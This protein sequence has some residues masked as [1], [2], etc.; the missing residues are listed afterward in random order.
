MSNLTPKPDTEWNI[1]SHYEQ[2]AYLANQKLSVMPV[3]GVV[4]GLC[5]CSQFH[6]DLKDVG[7][8]PASAG[9]QKDATTDQGQ[10]EKWWGMNP[11]WNLAIHCV[12]CGLVVFDFDPRNG[13]EDSYWRL[14]D[15]TE[16]MIEDTWIVD[17]GVYN[18]KGK[19]LRG[20]HIYFRLEQDVALVGD[21]KKLGYPG[22]DVKRNGYVMA[23]GSKHVSG[24]EYSWRK[25]HAPWE[26]PLAVIPQGLLETVIKRGGGSGSSR[27]NRITD[28]EG[29]DER[30]ESVKSADVKATPYAQAAL[31]RCVA[32]LKG[33]RRGDSRNNAMNAM[34][35]SLGHL[36]GGGQI[37][38]SK[39]RDELMAAAAESYGGDWTMKKSNTESVLREYGGG[40]EEG[41]LSPLYPRQLTEDAVEEIKAAVIPFAEADNDR[42][43]ELVH[44]GFLKSS[45]L[46]S[47]SLL[48]AVKLLGPIKV[49]PG[50]EL[51]YYKDGYWQTEA[52]DE[53]T[54]RVSLLMGEDFLTRYVSEVS[55]LLKV[56]SQ[57]IVKMGPKEFL[58]LENGMLN[59]RTGLFSPHDP[60]FN[61]TVRINCAWDPYAT[62][63]NVDAWMSDMIYDDLIDLIW[64]IIGVCLYTGMGFQR[65]IF[66]DGSGRNGKGT[67][68]RLIS[69][70]IPELFMANVEFQR[71]GSDKFATSQLFRKILNVVGDLSASAMKDSS[72]FKMLTGE[73]SIQAERK[74]GQPFNFQNEATLLFSANKMPIGSDETRGYASRFLIVPFTKKTLRDDEID[75][76]LEDRLFAELPGVLVKAVAGLKRAMERKGFADVE[77]CRIAHQKYMGRIDHFQNWADESCEFTG[78]RADVV[79][80]TGMWSSY[81]FFCITNEIDGLKRL[82]FY[83]EYDRRFGRISQQVEHET[84]MFNQVRLKPS[85]MNF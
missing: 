36:I 33:M 43:L 55:K 10:V 85:L 39:C 62:C 50:K 37:S 12:R 11:D 18:V 1:L 27:V 57:K 81:Q 70:L 45:R 54:R 68:I 19:T 35:F 20:F 48:E 49:G 26:I 75:A 38:L 23:A 46:L 71:F 51:L 4:N 16:S 58:N 79:P 8:H 3:H 47:E 67:L 78:L 60:K 61:S 40:F 30:W 84:M 69:K 14:W 65:A 52:E 34:A 25:G 17:T 63:P 24:V 13:S 9:G 66:L 41:A 5:T 80:K 6:Y 77:R 2:A 21:M 64:E 31:K 74:Y 72:T 53:I 59:W 42:L 76:A 15:A 22:V 29:W 83:E 7:K 44:T 56:R 28:L 73:D 32:E 82:E